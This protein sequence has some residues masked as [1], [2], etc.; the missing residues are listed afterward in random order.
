MFELA[1][2][3][4]YYFPFFIVLSVSTKMLRLSNQFII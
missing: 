1:A 2:E 4:K 3:L